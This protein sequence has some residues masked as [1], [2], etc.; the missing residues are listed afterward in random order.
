MDISQIVRDQAEDDL[1]QDIDWEI[2]ALVERC[3]DLSLMESEISE[4]DAR[5]ILD[6]QGAFD[7]TSTFEVDEETAAAL[8]EALR[9]AREHPESLR[10]DDEVWA[11]VNAQVEEFNRTV[12]QQSFIDQESALGALRS[13]DSW[14]RSLRLTG[15]IRMPEYP[16]VLGTVPGSSA[17]G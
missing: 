16:S 12:D 1:E 6:S 4:S 10:S 14:A 3:P 7:Q 17:R 9:A 2:E 13:S 8:D 15:T 5:E 11:A